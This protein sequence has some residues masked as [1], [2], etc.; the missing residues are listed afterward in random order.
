[1]AKVFFWNKNQDYMLKLI[2]EDIK[3][4]SMTNH[5]RK[6]LRHICL[7]GYLEFG[8]NLQKNLNLKKA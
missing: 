8:N 6:L 2:L 1:M 4:G 5:N 7:E 3:K